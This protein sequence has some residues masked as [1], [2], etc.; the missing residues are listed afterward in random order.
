MTMNDNE[1]DK[2]KKRFNRQLRNRT[3][4]ILLKELEE[5]IFH[6]FKEGYNF[7]NKKD[8]KS[9]RGRK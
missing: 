8:A 7:R 1:Y 5:I 3:T 2:V 9:S 4:K 6:F